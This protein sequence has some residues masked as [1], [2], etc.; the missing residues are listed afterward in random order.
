MNVG[1]NARCIDEHGTPDCPDPAPSLVGR[2]DK[3]P[4]D[5]CRQQLQ[6][7]IEQCSDELRRGEWPFRRCVAQCM[8]NAGCDY[9]IPR[10]F[11]NPPLR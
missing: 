4:A 3:K 10:P 1:Q 8:D 6:E 7:C 5:E 2:K 11:Y 9:T